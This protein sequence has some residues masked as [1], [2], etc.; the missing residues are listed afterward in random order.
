MRSM[1][2]KKVGGVA[3][4]IAKY[5]GIDETIVRLLF[6]ATLFL[7]GFGLLAYLALWIAMPAAK[8]LQEQIDLE[9]KPSFLEEESFKTRMANVESQF[10]DTVSTTASKVKN[11]KFFKKHF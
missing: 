10:E 2:D 6:V 7:D 11:S 4:G 1:T 5:F 9:E 3:S 8:S